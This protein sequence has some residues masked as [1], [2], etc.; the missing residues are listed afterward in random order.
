MNR[1]F[2]WQPDLPDFRDVTYEGVT[3]VGDLP[4]TADLR[5]TDFMP[6]YKS[7]AIQDMFYFLYKKDITV[8]PIKLRTGFGTS[9]RI[10]GVSIRE[11][12][13]LVINRGL[14]VSNID[15]KRL[16]QSADA[17][18]QC[19]A[20]GY[21]FV[22]GCSLY[23]SFSGATS[24]IALPEESESALGGFVALAVGYDTDNLFVKIY[25]GTPSAEFNMPF[26]YVTNTTL[27][28]DFWTVRRTF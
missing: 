23:T 19:I 28:G 26:T 9:A 27:S 11:N 12:L 25:D 14:N 4:S 8:P 21:P 6:P 17:M 13:K 3:L 15:Y 22:F 2:N 18:K 20:D 1:T 24:T 5:T 7:T 10:T 16:T